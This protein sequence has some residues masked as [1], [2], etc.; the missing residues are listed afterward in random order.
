[1]QEV[2]QNAS[3]HLM[4]SNCFSQVTRERV[5]RP[6]SLICKSRKAL[7]I[8]KSILPPKYSDILKDLN[9]E[10]KMDET[11]WK[12]NKREEKSFIPFEIVLQKQQ[13][14][15]DDFDPINHINLIIIYYRFHEIN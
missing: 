15:E 2:R 13:K 11:D 8:L 9:A 3:L 12:L 1:M 10:H 6:A 7:I 14:L 4:A 5:S